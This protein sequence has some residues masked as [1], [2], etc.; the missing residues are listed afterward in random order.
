MSESFATSGDYEA[1]WGKTD[2]D[3]QVV[4]LLGAASRLVRNRVKGIDARTDL[5]PDLIADI[6]CVMVR[7]VVTGPTPGATSQ[8][9]SLGGVSTSTSYAGSAGRLRLTDAQLEILLPSKRSRASST[10]SLPPVT[11]P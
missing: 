4:V 3:G 11:A 6:V 9:Q 8:S 10:S 5:D 1:R 2:D 7:E